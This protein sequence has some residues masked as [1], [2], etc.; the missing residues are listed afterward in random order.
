[1]P[2]GITI[3]VIGAIIARIITMHKKTAIAEQKMAV[4]ER[5]MAV[6]EEYK[7]RAEAKI[8]LAEETQDS[9]S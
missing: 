6:A 5:K 8:A 3:L 7:V 2:L 9:T 1:M 4:A